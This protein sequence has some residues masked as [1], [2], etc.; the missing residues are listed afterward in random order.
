MSYA[1]L[2]LYVDAQ[3]G[4]AEVVRLAC[5]LSEKFNAKLVGVSAMPVRPLSVVNGVVVD[6]VTE[7]ELDQMRL[8]LAGKEKWFQ[9]IA[10]ANRRA[11]EWRSGIDRPTDALVAEAYDADLVIA[12]SGSRLTSSYNSLDPGETILKA[13]RPV[14]FVPDKVTSFQGD[15]VVIGWKGTREA[16]RV[17]CDALPFLHEAS[18][19][20][21]AEICDAGGEDDARARIDGVARYLARHR[22]KAGP[23]VIL[24][25][26]GSVAAQLIRLA[27]EEAADLLVTGAY[28]HSRLG[29]WIFGGVTHDLLASSPICCLMSH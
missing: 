29:E 23:K 6:T 12:G 20:T 5:Q 28:G 21:I 3:D 18:R 4:R 22:I 14:L 7:T 1:T 26:D 17:L 2:M 9:D 16:R 15:H 27:E 8:R 10:A 13:G 19:V 25:R 24:H 11:A